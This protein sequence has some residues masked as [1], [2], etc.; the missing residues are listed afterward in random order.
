MLY[1]DTLLFQYWLWFL[2]FIT[3]SGYSY[4]LLYTTLLYAV[5]RYTS[6]S[7]LGMVLVVYHC[8]WILLVNIIHNNVVWCAQ[9]III[10]IHYFLN[11]GYGPCCLSLYLDTLSYYYTQHCCMLCTGTLLF[12]YWV[13]SLL[14]ITVSGYSLLLL[15]TTLL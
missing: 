5:H 14:S 4:L 8:I 9:I 10:I 7:I 2:L 1:T 3:V 15:Y 12:Q 11:T 13:W 6:I